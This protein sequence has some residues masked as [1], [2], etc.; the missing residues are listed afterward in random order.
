MNRASQFKTT[1]SK[2]PELGIKVKCSRRLFPDPFVCLTTALA[3]L[4]MQYAVLSILTIS[5]DPNAAYSRNL[6]QWNDIDK[7]KVQTSHHTEV[8]DDS[9]VHQRSIDFMEGTLN[10]QPTLHRQCVT[11]RFRGD[12]NNYTVDDAISLL[13]NKYIASPGS[14]RHLRMGIS[15]MEDVDL[16][17]PVR[18]RS[19]G[20]QYHMFHFAEM[21]VL[22]Y[23]TMHR[24]SSTLPIHA[25]HDITNSKTY[26]VTPT[27]LSK[28]SPSITVPWIFS[29]YMS[30]LEIC[31]GAT[32]INCLVADLI[33]Q[34]SNHSVFSSRTGIVGLNAMEQFP[35]DYSNEKMKAISH[36]IELAD[37]V[38]GESPTFADHADGVIL[39]ERFGCDMGGINK[40]WSAYI[41]MFPAYSWHSDLLFGLG[42]RWEGHVSGPKK[43]VLGYIDRQNTDRRLPDLH[44]NWIVEY[45][46]S[47]P[48]IDF[49]QLHM[50][51]YTAVEQIEKASECDLMIGMHGNGLTHT[52]WM[53]PRR[54]VIELFWK[55]NYQF[56]YATIAHMMKHSYMGILNGKVVDPAR[57]ESR[58]PSLRKTPTRKEAQHASVNE[59]MYFFEHEGKIAIQRFI[60]KAMIELHIPL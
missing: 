10:V 13:A 26:N 25:G 39:V 41:D 14:S 34:G 36:R 21:L 29:P 35:F 32:K 3:L 24:I 11:I 18:I 22:S 46:T 28:G 52:L 55:Y 56:D 19:Y 40:P 49:K 47:H 27:S 59:S 9:I 12:E 54:Y 33:L 31:G 15:I 37:Y 7:A 38:Y 43:F 1:T 53:Q 5:P 57:V 60:E 58:D 42:R 50:E 20:N 23:I 16:F 17:L 48:N 6:Q 30:P 8:P 4:L 2:M 45:A 51:A 44:H